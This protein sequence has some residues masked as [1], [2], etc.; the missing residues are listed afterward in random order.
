M[1][2]SRNRANDTQH[3]PG[4]NHARDAPIHG[5]RV[6]NHDT[7]I[8]NRIFCSYGSH[9]HMHAAHGQGRPAHKLAFPGNN[10]IIIITAGGWINDT[11]LT[12]HTGRDNTV[13]ESVLKTAAA[14]L[15]LKGPCREIG[16]FSDLIRSFHSAADCRLF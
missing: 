1:S 9:T 3:I 14:T 11:R 8:G 16:S 12:A 6:T 4:T 2:Y 7:T 5:S 13:F 10:N 15:R